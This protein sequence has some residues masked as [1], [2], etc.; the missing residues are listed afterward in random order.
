[1]SNAITQTFE[2]SRVAFHWLTTARVV[3]SELASE[4]SAV[5]KLPEEVGHRVG[6][7]KGPARRSGYELC[8]I[9]DRQSE[10]GSASP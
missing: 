8:R 2:S 6:P 4:P 7:E 3:C 5:T 9:A 1:M 10:R